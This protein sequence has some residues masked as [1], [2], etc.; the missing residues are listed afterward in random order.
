MYVQSGTHPDQ[1]RPAM[2]GGE[3][4]VTISP[5]A[6][7]AQLPEKCRLFARITVPAGAS[8]GAHEHQGECEMFYI[9]E[10]TPLIGD[11]DRSYRAHPGDCILTHSGHS[12]CVRNDTAE[13]VAMVACI[14][15]D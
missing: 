3:G 12:H 13:P 8:I 7:G 6:D 15:K 11:D 4:T 5:I 9:L 2:R 14:V 10:G 1:L